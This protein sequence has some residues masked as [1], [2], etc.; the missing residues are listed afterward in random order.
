[1]Y[2]FDDN[3]VSDLHKDARGFRPGVAWMQAWK[4]STGEEKQGIWDSLCEEVKESIAREQRMAA[5]AVKDFESDINLNIALGA[6]DRETALRWMTQTEEF[7]NDQCIE[8][9]VWNRDILFTDY[10]RELIKELKTIVT[11]KEYA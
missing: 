9:W 2:T 11:F 1:M 8:H 4:T 10:G 3:I 6:G 7:Y 5:E